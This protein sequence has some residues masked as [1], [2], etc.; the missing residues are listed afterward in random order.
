LDLFSEINYYIEDSSYSEEDIN[1]IQ[2]KLFKIQKFLRKYKVTTVTEL[3][4]KYKNLS[5]QMI[6]IEQSEIKISKLKEQLKNET[7]VLTT[8][9]KNLSEKRIQCS[10]QLEKKVTDKLKL[11]AMAD[12]EFK[13]NIEF[14]KKNMT[15]TGFDK[16]IFMIKTNK[17]SEFGPLKNVVSGGEMSRLM[18]TLK[19]LNAESDEIPS[20]IFDEID[21]GISGSTA[22]KVADELFHLGKTRQVMCITHQPAIAAIPGVHYKIEKFS[23]SKQT[24]TMPKFLTKTEKIEEVA[25]LMAGGKITKSNLIS[26]QELI[27]NFQKK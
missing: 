12:A 9:A 19:S 20:I 26:A 23:D 11:L 18:L 14:D 3:E 21:S 25:N 22:S 16:I 17:G 6:N 15:Q 7:N 4:N 10:K 8:I 13:I 27:N 5:E 1:S 2:E 24:I